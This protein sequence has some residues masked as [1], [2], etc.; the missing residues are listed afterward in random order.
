METYSQK[1]VTFMSF[2]LDYCDKNY[3][4]RI[5]IAVKYVITFLI[6]PVK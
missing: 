2:W 1:P 6:W 4:E 3:I 5:P